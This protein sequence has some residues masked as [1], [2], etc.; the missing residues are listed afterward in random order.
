MDILSSLWL[1]W[2]IFALERSEILEQN[3]MESPYWP[4]QT[5][6]KSAS[7]ATD[8]LAMQHCC[9]CGKYLRA[10][11]HAEAVFSMFPEPS[12]ISSQSEVNQLFEEG[13]NSCCAESLSSCVVERGAELR[14]RRIPLSELIN[15]RRGA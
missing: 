14:S 6:T 7:T 12:D 9:D 3:V 13:R 1:P 5:R 11:A 2:T 10:A 8:S 4:F 15:L